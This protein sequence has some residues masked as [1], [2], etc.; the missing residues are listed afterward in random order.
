MC[1]MMMDNKSDYSYLEK[2]WGSY[3]VIDIQDGSTT[4][5]VTLRNNNKMKYHS[6]KR[7]DEV[8][9][10]IEGCGKTKI[11]GIEKYVNTGDVITMEANIPHT[12]QAING[13]LKIIEV[14][15]G[16]DIDVNDK[17]VYE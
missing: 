1:Y 13:D 14:Q 9:T 11:D 15:L 8:W 10:I 7:R 6:H 12:I 3:K 17:T 16:K 2:S 4:I 5:L